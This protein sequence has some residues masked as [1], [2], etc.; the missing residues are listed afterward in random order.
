MKPVA[1]A[2]LVIKLGGKILEEAAPRLR[3]CEQIAVLAGRGHRI[4]VIHGGGKQVTDLSRRLGIPVI[5]YQGRRVTDEATL[6]VVK[7]VL[8]SVNGEL[9]SGLVSRGI[10]AI[11]M[12]SFE[13][14]LLR[15]RK[16]PPVTLRINGKN[17]KVDFGLVADVEGADLRFLFRLWEQGLLPVFSC[18][19]ADSKGQI[20]NLNA[21]TLACELAVALQPAKL[22]FV[23]DVDGIYL[24]P[25]DPSTRV[26]E[27]EA[28]QART[29]LK[30]GSLRKGMVPKV[31]TAL[32]ALTRGSSL[33]Q[34]VSG[35]TENGLL[36]GLEGRGGTRLVC[37]EVTKR[38]ATVNSDH[39]S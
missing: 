24:D 26:V 16:R 7:K 38:T 8:S 21:D 20:L 5:Q 29:Y 2:A 12:A 3:L 14:N 15:C 10:A 13:A 27:L 17:Q 1:E 33:V 9:T 35:L 28:E 37:S 39:P 34:I 32:K 11:G 19:C 4:V 36:E 25:L 6:E 31:E 30:Q 18:L 23:S 22:I